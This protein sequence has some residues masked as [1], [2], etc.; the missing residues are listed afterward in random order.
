MITAPAFP[1][2]FQLVQK[3]L[4]YNRNLVPW[5]ATGTTCI[6]FCTYKHS[7]TLI[8]YSHQTVFLLWKHVQ[9]LHIG[10]WNSGKA[11]CAPDNVSWRKHSACVDHYFYL[12]REWRA[13]VCRAY[14]TSTEYVNASDVTPRPTVTYYIC[15]RDIMSCLPVCCKLHQLWVV[16]LP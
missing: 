15:V 10:I 14:A 16:P 11:Q 9:R 4:H 2:A 3:L 8:F 6:R 1:S 5:R 13:W 12:T 7:F